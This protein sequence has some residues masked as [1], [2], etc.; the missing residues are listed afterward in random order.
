MP[1]RWTLTT[2]FSP[3]AS[4]ARCTCAM[5]AEPSASSSMDLKTWFQRR[6]YSFS[7]TSRMTGNGSGFAPDC[8]F[9]SSSQ[10]SGGRK[11]GRML[12][13]W[14]SLTNVG[15]RSSRTWRS[16]TGVMP[17]TTS[18]LRRTPIIS[19]RRP[20]APASSIAFCKNLSSMP[21]RPPLSLLHLTS[22]TFPGAAGAPSRSRGSR[23]TS[24]G[25]RRHRPV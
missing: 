6:L 5:L 25:G 3:L 11:S 22:C 12:M 23:R 13:I 15:P 14:P 20:V 24:R 1:G 21:H 8:N 4:T 17:R 16:L 9:M 18:R 19:R 7:M 2:T 10:Y